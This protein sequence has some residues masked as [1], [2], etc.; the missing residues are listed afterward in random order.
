MDFHHS[1]SYDSVS[2]ESGIFAKSQ[3]DMISQHGDHG[4]SLESLQRALKAVATSIKSTKQTTKALAGGVVGLRSSSFHDPLADDA[5]TAVKNLHRALFNVGKA[6][7]I[8]S[9][10]LNPPEDSKEAKSTGDDTLDVSESSVTLL[11]FFEVH[12]ILISKYDYRK[13]IYLNVCLL[14]IIVSIL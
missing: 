11:R 4:N 10:G 1:N 6:Q 14:F 3:S 12:D 2:H 7:K 5:A 13:F 8:V 9:D